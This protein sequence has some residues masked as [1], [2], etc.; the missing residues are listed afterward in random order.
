MVAPETLVHQGTET[1]SLVALDLLLA[2]GIS[3]VAGC[4]QDSLGTW[5]S[6][7]SDLIANPVHSENTEALYIRKKTSFEPRT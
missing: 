5:S 6:E 3:V 7:W 2:K 4:R 1:S